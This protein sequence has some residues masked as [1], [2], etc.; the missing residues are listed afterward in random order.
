MRDG[1]F[2]LTSRKLRDVTG[3]YP[4]LDRLGTALAG[5]QL[6][7]DGEILALDAAGGPAF[8]SFSQE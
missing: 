7:L 3:S 6:I 8:S 4:E 5:H 2:R 1:A